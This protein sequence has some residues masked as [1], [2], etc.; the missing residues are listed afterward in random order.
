MNINIWLFKAIIWMVYINIKLLYIIKIFI[1]IIKFG[2]KKLII[3]NLIVA[4]NI[5]LSYKRLLNIIIANILL[6]YK[7]CNILFFNII[8]KYKKAAF[9][10][11]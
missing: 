1:L 6:R 3:L 7:N 4:K 11:S 2:Y 10:L 8:F 9:L 5:K